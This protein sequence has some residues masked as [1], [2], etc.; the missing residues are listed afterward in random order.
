MRD[1]RRVVEEVAARYPA[2][3]IPPPSVR[4]HSMPPAFPAS[5]RV[6]RAPVFTAAVAID[7][8]KYFS[9]C[10]TSHHL[11]LAEHSKSAV[12]STMSPKLLATTHAGFL[13]L[14]VMRHRDRP[15]V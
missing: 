13:T 2:A 12:R 8:K 10:N 7:Q 15:P 3:P 5:W 11:S 1:K 4:T 6:L 9:A 14:N